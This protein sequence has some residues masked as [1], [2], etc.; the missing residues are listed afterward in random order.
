MKTE[1][2]IHKL[3]LDKEAYLSEIASLK[4]INEDLQDKV[5]RLSL[6]FD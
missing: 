4:S 3:E 1:T 6:D 2:N 5:D